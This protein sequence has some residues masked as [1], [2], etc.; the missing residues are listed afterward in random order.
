[1]IVNE[2]QLIIPHPQLIF[3][4][5]VLVPLNEIA[6]DFI[7]PVLGKSISALLTEC[8]DKSEVDYINI[9]AI[10]SIIPN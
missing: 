4:K 2:E 5:F 10:S 7:H 1:S 6:P 8:T 9:P 3:R